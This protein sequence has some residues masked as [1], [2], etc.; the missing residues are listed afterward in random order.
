M[1]P[2]T[3][4][5][6][7]DRNGNADDALSS[8]AERNAPDVAEGAEVAPVAADAAKDALVADS[9]EDAEVA[10]VDEDVADVADDAPAPIADVPEDPNCKVE[11]E[12][13][14]EEISA[15]HEAAKKDLLKVIMEMNM[16][17][18]IQESS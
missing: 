5:M 2:Q 14:V 6:L 16:D 9:P 4:S 11:E 12:C 18:G 13:P 3:R 8:V 17:Y 7:D 1:E 10:P 15:S